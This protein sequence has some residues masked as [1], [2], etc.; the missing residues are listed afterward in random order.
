MGELHSRAPVL[1]LSAYRL[2][3]QG[4]PFGS[5]FRR[6]HK[7]RRSLLWVR[8]RI[9]FLPLRELHSSAAGARVQRIQAFEKERT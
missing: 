6:K 3:V 7:L 8:S 5:T 2:L 1:A 9:R 4:T